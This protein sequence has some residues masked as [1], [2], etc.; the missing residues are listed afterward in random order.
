MKGTDPLRLSNHSSSFPIASR[1]LHLSPAHFRPQVPISLM[2]LKAVISR[3]VSCSNL[4]FPFADKCRIAIFC[5][6]KYNDLIQ[7]GNRWMMQLCGKNKIKS[8]STKC[9]ISRLNICLKVPRVIDQWII[10][11][12]A[13]REHKILDLFI[14]SNM[15]RLYMHRGNGAVVTSFA[16]H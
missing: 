5:I 15:Q 12:I 7:E 10:T 8:K 3:W 1:C 16:A 9:D 4:T 13:N 11:V 2:K 14:Q 6:N